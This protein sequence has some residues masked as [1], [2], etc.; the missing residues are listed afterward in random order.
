MT[1]ETAHLSGQSP[2][3]LGLP[4][5]SIIVTNYNYARFV[6]DCLRSIARQSYRHIECLIIDDVSTD[7]SVETIRRVIA[8]LDEAAA[9]EAGR[10]QLI[11][12]SENGGQMNAFI[13]GFRQATGE[14]VVFVDADDWL[15]ADFVETHVAAHLNPSHTAGLSCSNEVLVD[16]EGRAIGGGFENWQRP[17]PDGGPDGRPGVTCRLSPAGSTRAV[18]VSGW[19]DAWSLGD[20]ARFG[21]AGTAAGP[22]LVHV[23]HDGNPLRE[24]IWSTTSAIMFRRRVLELVLTDSARPIRICADYYLLQFSHLIGGSLLVQAAHGCYR[25]HGANG[26]AQSGVIGRGAR[27]GSNTAEL[28]YPQMIDLI[29][30][31]V[32]AR[33]PEF[34]E[35]LGEPKTLRLLA[36]LSPPTRLGAALGCIGR[37]RWRLKGTFAGL[38]VLRR[39][40]LAALAL[41]ERLRFA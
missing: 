29:R 3:S 25:R 41:R 21:G 15:F 16:A 6:G 4:L 12:L 24:W 32:V 7:G 30:H 14:F 36:G 9:A 37:G 1:E 40:R 22:D 27:L 28:S 8:D 10:F 5:V 31:E 38:Y 11:A 26:F 18:P 2:E 33:Y 17:C 19:R 20:R 35:A 13:E 34:C 39:A 23:D